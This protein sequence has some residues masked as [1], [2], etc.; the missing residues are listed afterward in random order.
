MTPRGLEQGNVTDCKSKP[1]CDSPKTGGAESGAQSAKNT[2]ESPDTN[3][4]TDRLAVIADLLSDLPQAE[5]REVIAELPPADRAAIARMLI[6]RC[7]EG[8]R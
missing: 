3:P 6:G 1:L 5:R 4:D 7:T 8:K 2:P